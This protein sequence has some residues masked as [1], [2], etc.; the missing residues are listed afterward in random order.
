MYLSRLEPLGPHRDAVKH[1]LHSGGA[2]HL[3]NKSRFALWCIAH[4]R[5][6]ARQILFR[7]EPDQRQNDWL[8][9]LSIDRPDVHISADIL[10]IS[11]RS[12]AVKRLTEGGTI[13][14]TC[15][16]ISE[17]LKQ[18]DELLHAI[19]SLILQVDSWTSSIPMF[20]RPRIEEAPDV[21]RSNLTGLTQWSDRDQLP[22]FP[23]PRVLS[24]HDLWLAYI[25]NLHT[26]SQIVL[27]ESLVDLMVYTAKLSCR[28]LTTEETTQI[29]VERA[30]VDRLCSAIIQSL[31]PL[32]GLTQ[33]GWDADSRLPRKGAMVGRFFALLSMW[34]VVKAQYTSDLHKKTAYEVIAWISSRHGL[35]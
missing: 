13:K 16:S 12:S 34:I 35:D 25:W 26:T 15:T 5:L 19:R 28:D 8:N 17:K 31:P 2:D 7:E 30:A 10:D 32:L 29:D 9:R 24:Y 20:W 1:I 27:H 33:S 14:D 6:Q 4:K 22:L 3:Y 21:H 11:I 18:A 23:C